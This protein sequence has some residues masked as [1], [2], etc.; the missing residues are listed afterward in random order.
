MSR[1][2]IV[3]AL[4]VALLALVS[5]RATLR[6]AEAQSWCIYLPQF[7]APSPTP[8]PAPTSTPTPTATPAPTAT[9]TPTA[10]PAAGDPWP[11]SAPVAALSAQSYGCPAGLTFRGTPTAIWAQDVCA[12]INKIPAADRGRFSGWSALAGQPVPVMG[13]TDAT[14]RE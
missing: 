4:A 12:A 13:V 1:L 5:T 6:T 9:P 10:T 8:T 7:C 11:L 2:W 14:G 3:T